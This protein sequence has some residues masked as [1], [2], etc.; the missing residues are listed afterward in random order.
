MTG[1]LTARAAHCKIDRRYEVGL[2]WGEGEERGRSR[3]TALDPVST[4]KPSRLFLVRAERLEN[5]HP[6]P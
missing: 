4:D 3:H 6:K 5:W 2:C 1:W